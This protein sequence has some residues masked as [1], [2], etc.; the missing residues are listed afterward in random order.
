M[1]LVA[2]ADVGQHYSLLVA[3]IVSAAAAAAA[4]AST[5]QHQ[6]RIIVRVPV[7]R[8]HTLYTSHDTPHKSHVTRH[9]SHVTRHTAHV[10]FKRPIQVVEHSMP[11]IDDVAVA[12]SASTF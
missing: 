4:N 5:Q 3:E 12:A 9:T 1:C 2:V 6:L 10:T 7:E 11:E 8:V